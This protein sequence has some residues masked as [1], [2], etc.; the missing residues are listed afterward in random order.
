MSPSQPIDG[1]SLKEDRA[2]AWMTDNDHSY[3]YGHKIMNSQPMSQTV[4]I[5]Q[6]I[7]QDKYGELFDSVLIN[8]YNTLEPRNKFIG[9][10]W[11]LFICYDYYMLYGMDID[12]IFR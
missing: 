3:T 9:L 6:N 1:K 5:I 2:T 7:I 12:F 8:Y 10:C 11:N 4:K